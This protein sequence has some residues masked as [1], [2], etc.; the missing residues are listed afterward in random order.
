MLRYF[1]MTFKKYY[2]DSRYT[3]DLDLIKLNLIRLDTPNMEYFSNRIM[4]L[5]LNE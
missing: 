5:K 1:L 3:K 4:E 2:N